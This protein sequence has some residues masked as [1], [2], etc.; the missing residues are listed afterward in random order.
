[1]TTVRTTCPYCGVGCGLLATPEGT[2]KGDP[3]HPANAGRLCSKGAALAETIDL[4]GR[5]LSPR[6]KGRPAGWDTALDLVAARFAAAIHTHGPDSVAF[7]VSGQL[8]SEDYYVANKLMKGFIGSANIDTNSRLCMASSVAGHKRAFGADTVP[9]TYTDLDQAELIVLTGSNLAW[10]HPVLFQRILAAR[11]ARPALKIIT[12]DPRR[13]ATS[14]ASDLHLAIRPNGDTTLFGS[15][16]SEIVRRGAVDRDYVAAHVS[17]FEQTVDAARAMNPDDTGLPADDI[18][19]FH[20]MWIGAEK[21]VTVFSQGVNQ[22]LGGTDKVNAILNCHLATGRIGR[23]GMGPFSVTGQPNAMGG[24]EV[25]GLANTLACHLEIENPTHRKAVQQ[26]WRSPTICT[27]PGLKA[28]DLFRACESGRIKALWIMGTNPAVSLP[29]ADSVSRAIARVDFT[30]VSEV[31]NRTD[32]SILTDVQLPATAWGEKT[33]TVTNSERRI[34]LQRAFLPAPGETR[35]DWQI[36]CEVARRMGWGDAFAFDS[37]AAI[38]R[39]HA[40]LSGR[41]AALGR[42]FDISGLADISDAEYAAL[43]PVQWP[44]TSRAAGTERFFAQG[45]F[46]HADGK[47][48]MVPVSAMPVPAD[49]AQTLCLNTGRIRD[50]WHTMTRSG[51]S[52][53]L[54]QNQAEPF[55]EIHPKDARFLGV[56]DAELLKIESARGQAVV[57][58]KITDGIGP[59]ALFVPMHWSNTHAP[60]GRINACIPAVTDPVSGQPA[61]KAVQVRACRFTPHWYGFAA[62]ARA[63][64]PGLAYSAVARTATGW[65]CELAGNAA[66]DNWEDQARRIL[67]LD[68]GGVSVMRDPARGTVR[69]AIHQGAVLKGVFF[70]SPRPIRVARELAIS[71]INRD[72]SALVALAGLPMSDQPDPGPIVCACFNVGAHAIHDAIRHGATSVEAV[73]KCTA[74]GTNCGSCKPDLQA[75]IDARPTRSAAEQEEIRC[76]VQPM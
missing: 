39:E 38:F 75:L 25:G 62:S 44:V 14:A 34:S 19:R 23:P 2:I 56:A 49:T 45:G 61:S 21:V 7:Y 22:S 3:D 64:S 12:I 10:C 58:A 46:F 71:R 4:E 26:A 33:G 11:A 50:Q 36:I 30:V 18:R 55:A 63:M 8:L 47:A 16:L 15:L 68:T 60:T 73:G 74:A 28:V 59:G 35:P 20:D 29:D 5:L 69:I 72:V 66:P 57:R 48:R 27:K 53:R 24:R 51:K 43:A 1:M 41:A 6:I 70:A 40:A 67:N 37:P 31:V 13:T 52:A 17:G 32:T 54:N 65:R 76:H 9:G 42:D